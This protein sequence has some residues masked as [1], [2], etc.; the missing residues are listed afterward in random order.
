MKLK[1]LFISSAIYMALL[2][3]GFIFV[4]HQIGTGAVPT[5]ANSALIA[6]L[7]V[8]GSTFVAIGVLNWVARNSVASEARNAIVIANIVGFGLAAVLDIWGALSG[9]RG[10][11]WLLARALV[12]KANR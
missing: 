10:L 3:I 8:F 7:R 2:G 6:Y 4:P 9:G 5:D 12:P 1:G 11:A